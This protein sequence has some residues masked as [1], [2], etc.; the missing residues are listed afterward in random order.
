MLYAFQYRINQPQIDITNQELGKM[1]SYY[2]I[3]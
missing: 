1:E 2:R 3:E